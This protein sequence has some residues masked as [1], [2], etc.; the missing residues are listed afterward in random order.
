MFIN[1]LISYHIANI[2]IINNIC[3]NLDYLLK[4]Y[5]VNYLD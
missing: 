5:K 2:E 3:N 4:P 1:E